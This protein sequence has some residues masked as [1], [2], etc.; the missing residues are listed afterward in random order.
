MFYNFG[1]QLSS[2]IEKKEYLLAM[3]CNPTISP[4]PAHVT[5]VCEV[6]PEGKKFVTK[7][8]KTETKY[9]CKINALTT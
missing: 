9:E 5:D 4:T 3:I 6:Y 1:G 8:G 7:V 2:V